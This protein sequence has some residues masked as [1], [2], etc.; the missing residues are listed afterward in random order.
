[1]KRKLVDVVVPDH[2]DVIEALN[3]AETIE[4]WQGAYWD[5]V[6]QIGEKRAKE[7]YTNWRDWIDEE[8]GDVGIPVN[9]WSIELL[10]RGQARTAKPDPVPIIALESSEY[11]RDEMKERLKALGVPNP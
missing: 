5:L 2:N 9:D 6:A 8:T 11:D 10:R 7:H 1:M 3:E 4:A